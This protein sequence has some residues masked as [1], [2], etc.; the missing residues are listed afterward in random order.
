MISKFYELQLAIAFSALC[1]SAP[2]VAQQPV[3]WQIGFQ[4]AADERMA[5]IVWLHSLLMWIMAAV[6]LLVLGLL[7]YVVLRFNERV[8]P[9]PSKTTHNTLLEVVWTIVPVSLL[10]IVAVPSFGILYQQDV[11]P[12]ADIT[13]KAIGKQWYWTYEYPDHG[14]FAFD[15]L[16]IEES[17]S[18]PIVPRG[19]PRLLGTSN[20]VVVPVNT[21]VRLLVTAADVIHA[22]ALPSFG[23]KIDAVPGRINETWFRPTELGVYYGQCSELCGVRHAFMP[24]AVEVVTQARFAEWVGDAQAQ[25]GSIER[26]QGARVASYEQ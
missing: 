23:V 1:I 14:N 17:R 11:I 13:I 16:M 2:A 9:T 8:H 5:N 19:E 12:E 21:T 4:P 6:C 26:P 3:D 25:F 22:W 15:A 18:A 7:V 10:V 24:I 20:R